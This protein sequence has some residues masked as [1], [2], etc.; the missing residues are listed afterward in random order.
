[1]KKADIEVGGHYIAKVSGNLVTVRVDAIG[2]TERRRTDRYSGQPKYTIHAYYEVTNLNT[3]RK[4]TFR[5]AQKF[6]RK[7]EGASHGV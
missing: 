6:R 4:L 1:M 7:T 5:S 3:G 2:E